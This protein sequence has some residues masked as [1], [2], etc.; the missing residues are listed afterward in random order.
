MATTAVIEIKADNI[1]GA[2]D[3]IIRFLMGQNKGDVIYFDGWG[4]LGASAVL[5]AIARQLK[6][7]SFLSGEASRT[8]IAAGLD[9][10]IHIDCSLWQSMRALQK[11]IAED[12]DLPMQVM[13]LFDQWD[14]KDDFDGVEVGTRGLIPHV[15]QAILNKLRDRRFL[16]IFHNG[17]GIY[18]DL[19]DF[20]VP[21][22]WILSKRVLWTSRGRF[23]LHSIKDVYVKKLA[24]LSNVLIS[25]NLSSDSVLDSARWLLQAEAEEVASYTGVPRPDMSTQIVMECILYM[26]LRGDDYGINWGTNASNYWVCDGIIEDATNGDRSAWEIAEA[27]HR[28]VRMDGWHRGWVINIRDTIGLCGE[29]WRRSDRWVSATHEHLEQQEEE[30]SH[31]YVAKVQLPPQTTSFF[32]TVAKS[33]IDKNGMAILEDFGHS[34]MTNLRVLHLSQCTFSFSSPPFLGCS[35]LRFLLL[36]HCKDKDPKVEADLCGQVEC[37]HNKIGRHNTTCFEVLW[38][39]DLNYTEW[40][41]LLSKEMMGLMVH[42][43]ELNVKGIKSWT[44]IR[45]LGRGSG[46]G[47]NLGKLQVICSGGTNQASALVEFPD[48]ST[49]SLKTI[50]LDGCVELEQL[51]HNVLPLL[52]ESFSFISN[53]AAKIRI[54]SFQGCTQ[55]KSLLLRGLFKN[56]E[57]M[58]MSRT[59]IKMLDL[60]AIQAPRLNKIFL[61][62]CEKLQA[63]LW[64]MEGEKPKLDVLHIDTTHAILAGEDKSSK[65]EA[66]SGDTSVGSPSTTV[67]HADQAHVNFNFYISLRNARFLR[68]LLHVRLGNHVTVEISSAANIS[69]TD[70]YKEARPEMQKTVDNLYKDVMKDCFKD[71]S[72]D[73]NG[74]KSANASGD[75]PS[76]MYMWPCPSNPYKSNCIHCYISIQ[77]EMQTNLLQGTTSVKEASSGITLPDFVH[78]KARSLHLHDCLSITSI[79]GPSPTSVAVDLSWRHLQWCRIESCP[80][81]EGTVFNTPRRRD[82]F[83]RYLH[84]FWA[85]QLLKVLHIWGWWDWDISLFQP[86]RGWWDWD[87]SFKA[88]EFLHLDRCPRLVHVLPLCAANSNGC[89]SL[90]TLEIVCC[91]ALREVFPLDSNS[92]IIFPWLKH[93]HLHELPKLQRICG[94][95]M[96]APKLK[97]MKIRG[98]WSLRRLP[99]VGHRGTPPPTVDCEKEWWD[100][101]E[102]EGVEANHHPSLYKPIHSHYYKKTLRRTSLLR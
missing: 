62:G 42:L 18:I 66:A 55:L 33:M 86:K 74:D 87:T 24:G 46:T 52:L 36:D 1:N 59:A 102:W 69:T 41:W 71:I 81:L 47:S 7:S 43:R 9:N 35:N 60:S 16:V 96:S 67:L 91:G 30:G 40:Y 97:T 45:H 22:S 64:P 5:K 2:A 10:I 6:S 92:V 13:A 4:G 78:D 25:A 79:L 89:C 32:V 70:C 53:V 56:L 75:A 85:S 93:I 44:W 90:V 65:K 73:V 29:M 63:I 61:L 100:G 76:M 99:S 68:S 11:A 20:G 3:E 21:T 84:T 58:D 31:D 82:N 39:L 51:D 54:I 17:S 57:E 8:W 88:L 37:H 26:A 72:Q 95:M 19:Q 14:E 15:T 12:L 49:S 27:L 94:H 48:L 50:S 80:N 101:L 83:F 28:T 77:D 23:S 38:V 98:C 34:D